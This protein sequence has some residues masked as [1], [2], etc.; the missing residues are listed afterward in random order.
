MTKQKLAQRK[1]AKPW[2]KSKTG[3]H[4]ARQWCHSIQ[5]WS[6]LTFTLPML[7]CVIG[8]L[9]VGTSRSDLQPY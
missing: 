6:V 8:I 3:R 9:H 2:P 1:F 7:R 5:D 4:W